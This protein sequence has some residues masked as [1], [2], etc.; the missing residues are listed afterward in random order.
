MIGI[1]PLIT[2]PLVLSALHGPLSLV[3]WVLGAVVAACDGLV[4][5]EL[6][7]ALPR[8]GGL[9]AFFLHLFS[10]K[11]GRLLAFLFVWQF[12]LTTPFLLASGYIGFSQYA[13]YLAPQLRGNDLAQHL[14]AVAIGIVTIV[15][16]ARIITRVATIAVVLFVAATATLVL[17]TV[18]AWTRFDAHQAFAVDPGSTALLPFVAGLGSGLIVTLYDYAGYS[19]VTTIGEEIAAAPRTIPRSILLA[20]ALV[21][22]L[23]LALQTGVLGAIP[24]HELV[25]GAAGP[26]ESARFVASSVVE[27]AWGIGAAGVATV[28]ILITAF[29]STFAILLSAARVPFAAARDGLFLAA[30]ARLHPRD[31]YPTVSLFAIG[32]LALGACFLPLDQIIAVIG[33]GIVVFGGVGAFASVVRLRRSDVPTPYRMPL[34][35]LPALVALAAWLYVLATAG[36]LAVGFTAVSIAAG[37]GVYY[38]AYARSR[39]A[40]SAGS[41]TS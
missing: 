5:A 32:T 17:V 3:A 40:A 15:L 30:F 21:A 10:P 8:S 23:Y 19:T 20:I 6:G 16:L 7:A 2:I 9:Y 4:W 25:G 36:A 11:A 37:I 35:P 33:V 29:A 38:L 1:G 13:T 41:E 27:R 34:F 12:V 39:T 14:V 26:S 22:A 31:A 24:W 18:A 28:L